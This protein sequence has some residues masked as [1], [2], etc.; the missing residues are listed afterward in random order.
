MTQWDF[1]KESGSGRFTKI[2]LVTRVIK[3]ATDEKMEKLIDEI[4]FLEN[5][6]SQWKNHFPEIIIAKKERDRVFYEMAHYPLP[7][8]RKLLFTGKFTHKEVLRWIDK[9][10]NFCHEMWNYEKIIPAPKNYIEYMHFGRVKRRLL[11]LQRKSDVLRKLISRKKLTINGEE[12][13][14]IPEMIKILKNPEIVNKVL[15]EYVSRWCHADMHFSNIMID[16]KNDNFILLDPRGYPYC[17]YYYDF[18]KLWHSVN[19]KYELI[20]EKCFTLHKDYF[21]LERNIV[22][23]ECEKIKA[24]LP[25]ILVKYSNEPKDIVMMKT[26]FNEAMH[27]A[28]LVPF[29]LD[30][31][32]HD[33]RAVAAY[34]TGVILL[35]DWYSK[36]VG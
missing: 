22:Y 19:G 32:G 12:Y 31:D 4:N 27:F 21:D 6:P 10:L 30:Y 23:F 13:K 7:T 24:K 17:D 1:G 2:F 34:Y 25:E 5:L 28:A 26:E 18:G 20:A 3:E 35:N 9:I 36:Y 15:P 11:E 14:N 8:L 29:I 16:E 33:E